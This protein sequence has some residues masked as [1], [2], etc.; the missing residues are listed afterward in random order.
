MLL[1]IFHFSAFVLFFYEFNCQT[2]TIFPM[3]G[4]RGGWGGH[5]LSAMIKDIQALQAVQVQAC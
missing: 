4:G 5:R 3:E 1:E 2:D